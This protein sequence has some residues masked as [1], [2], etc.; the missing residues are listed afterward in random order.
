MRCRK[1][2]RAPRVVALGL[3]GLAALA[4]I[5]ALAGCG[6]HAATT[7]TAPADATA[8]APGDSS[9]QGGS[10]QSEAE[11]TRAMEAKARE[12]DQ[13]AAEIQNMQGT[14][15]EK[16]DAVNKLDQERQ[17]LNRTGGDGSAPAATPPPQ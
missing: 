10:Y 16:I 9:S 1:T 5:L 2:C 6:R 8:A 14:E 12:L 13:K 11:R 3:A 4:A 17:D 7:G 15:Q